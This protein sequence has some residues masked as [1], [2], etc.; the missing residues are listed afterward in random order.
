MCTDEDYRNKLNSLVPFYGQD[1]YVSSSTLCQYWAADYFE[2]YLNQM[3]KP[4]S[5][6]SYVLGIEKDWQY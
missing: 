2:S 5:Q 3:P 6:S 4:L 1:W